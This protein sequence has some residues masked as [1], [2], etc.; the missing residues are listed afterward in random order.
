MLI[1]IKTKEQLKGKR[2]FGWNTKG[3]MDYLMGAKV[4]AEWHDC[5]WRVKTNKNGG[6]GYWL[7]SSN[8][9]V[10]EIPDEKIF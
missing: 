9:V 10:T 3:K 2:P 6:I 7:L 4:E 1:Q 8:E 5:G